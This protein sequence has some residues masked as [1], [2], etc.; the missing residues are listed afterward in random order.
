MLFTSFGLE[1]GDA[2]HDDMVE[3]QRLVVDLNLARKQ[4]AEVLHI[5]EKRKEKLHC[6]TVSNI[7]FF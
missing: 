1:I 4:A 5:P 6:S 7:I 3:E 2:M